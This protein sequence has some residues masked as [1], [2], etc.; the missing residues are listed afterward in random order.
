LYPALDNIV[1]CDDKAPLAAAGLVGDNG[2]PAA[3]DR[4]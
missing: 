3:C 2:R 1:G 4:P